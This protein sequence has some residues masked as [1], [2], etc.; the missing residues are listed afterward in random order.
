MNIDRPFTTKTDWVYH[1][2]R[3]EILEGSLKPDDR[4]RLSSLAQRFQTSEMP[5]REALRMLQR[6]GLISFANH[7]G[8]TV[9]KL[10]MERAAEIVSVRMHLE[11]LAIADATPHHTP[12]TLAELTELLERMDRQA[13]ARQAQRFT[14]TN[15]RFHAALYAPGS[16]DVLKQEIQILWDRVWRAR[17]RSI[18]A[19]DPLR[20]QAAQA[21]HRAILD[22]VRSGNTAVAGQAMSRHRSK[23]LGS[24]RDI[25]SSKEGADA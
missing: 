8:A 7:R 13:Q 14:E 25:G 4:L 5:V 24:W 17:P 18:F 9:V 19:I 1:R 20:M 12:D 3:G 11:V 16:N 23:T 21:E 2:L 10:S 22:A 15:R 6:D